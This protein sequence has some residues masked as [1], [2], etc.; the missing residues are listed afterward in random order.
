MKPKVLTAKV[1][2]YTTEN[3]IGTTVISNT[4]KRSDSRFL[5]EILPIAVA[6]LGLDIDNIQQYKFTI[7]LIKE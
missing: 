6:K 1:T 4:T 2:V 5:T 7:S 3:V